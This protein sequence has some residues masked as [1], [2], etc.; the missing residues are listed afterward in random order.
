MGGKA[1]Y[2][3]LGLYHLL[4]AVAFL[5]DEIIAEEAFELIV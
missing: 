3:T 5:W 4:A 1:A 2:C